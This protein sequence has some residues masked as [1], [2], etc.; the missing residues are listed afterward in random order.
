MFQLKYFVVLILPLMVLSSVAVAQDPTTESVAVLAASPA[1][2]LPAPEAGF[3]LDSAAAGKPS[4]GY[5]RVAPAPQDLKKNKSLRPFHSIAVGFNANSLGAS[6]EVATPVSRSFNLRSSLN[7]F[8]FD[9]PFTIDGL[10]YDARLHLKSTGTM[11]DWFPLHRAFHI[12]PGILYA[13]NLLTSGASAGA[14]QSFELGSQSYL[15][16]IDDLTQLKAVE[17]E[18]WGMADED[19]LPLTLAIACQAAGNIFVG[20]FDQEKLVALLCRI[21]LQEI[22]FRNQQSA[23]EDAVL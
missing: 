22:V 5:V 6:V 7:I 2:K 11:L 15:N 3:A 12:S 9:Y 18:V 20:A 4:S 16:S 13:K 14:G 10:N 23:L 1:L 17:K 21:K 19:A 8:A